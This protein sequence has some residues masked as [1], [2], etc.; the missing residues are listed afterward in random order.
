MSCDSVDDDRIP[1]SPVRIDFVSQ[2]EWDL[3]GIGGALQWRE[4][5]KQQRIPSG[6]PYSD[7]SQTGFGG[8][9]LVGDFIGDAQAYDMACPVEVKRDVRVS[10][11]TDGAV[12]R[13][14]VCGSTYDIFRQGAPISGKAADQGYAL[15]R[16]RVGTRPDGGRWI[17]N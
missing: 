12:A 3:Y 13:C 1:P 7:A 14:G 4:F 8:V 2:G 15:R 17:A 6:F 10:V 11:D 5:I 9:L 16:Y